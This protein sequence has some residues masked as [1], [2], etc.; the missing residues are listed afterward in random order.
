MSHL[1]DEL[2]SKFFHVFAGE[3]RRVNADI[4]LFLADLFQR[5]NAT[6][7]TKETVVGALTEWFEI[8]LLEPILDEDGDD[9]STKTS[10]EKALSKI[11]QLK[12]CGWLTEEDGENYMPIL[13][14]E[15]NALIII[16]ALLD[17]KSNSKPKEYSGYLVVMD[18]LL[19]DFDFNQGVVTLEQVYENMITFT[20]R[21][22]GLISSIR[23]FYARMLKDDSIDPR[24]HLDTLLNEYHE[25]VV[26][27]A[28]DNLKQKDN[29]SK[30]RGNILAQIQR[31]GTEESIERLIDNYRTV[32]G[33]QDPE[34]ARNW[35][36]ERIRFIETKIDQIPMTI[37]IIDQKNT[38]YIRS[39]QMKL[40]FLLTES[41][42]IEGKLIRIMRGMNRVSDDEAFAEA[43]A[44]HSMDLLDERSGFQPRERK[45][46]AEEVKLVMNPPV[47][48][49]KLE[50][51]RKRL[52]REDRTSKRSI[53]AYVRTLLTKKSIVRASEISLETAVD[54]VRLL[55]IRLYG[56]HPTMCYE[57][58]D[59]NQEIRTER[60]VYHDYAIKRKGTEPWDNDET[61]S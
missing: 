36:V 14:I 7:M 60:Y 2:D 28:F 48:E 21:L 31:I 37:E 50:E 1:F 8:A 19:R 32:K 9:L 29:P 47:D 55:L 30:F 59:L 17:I 38:K 56:H 6:F 49:K 40:N 3:Q 58:I 54:L 27:R 5:E 23:K 45:A 43:F 12:R 16:K 39:T 24:R 10:R 61:T 35:I 57:I 41:A 26:K 18:S 13:Q 53:N 25:N 44:L 52:F 22:Q 42:D 20:N 15:D 46:Q 33:E 34:I 4:I 11:K 51:A